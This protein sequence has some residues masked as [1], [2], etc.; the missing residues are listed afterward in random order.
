MPN[1]LLEDIKMTN[2]NPLLADWNA[3]YKIA[4]FDKILDDHFS[5]ALKKV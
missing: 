1:A 2:K 4:S 5:E 3:P